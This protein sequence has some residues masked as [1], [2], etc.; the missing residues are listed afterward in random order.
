MIGLVSA[1]KYIPERYS[2]QSAFFKY[3]TDVNGDVVSM[4]NVCLVGRERDNDH[5]LNDLLGFIPTGN[6]VQDPNELSSNLLSRLIKLP[7]KQP[8][9]MYVKFWEF[10]LDRCSR[11]QL[12]TAVSAF[13]D[14][15]S[16]FFDLLV[17]NVHDTHNAYVDYNELAFLREAHRRN[18]VLVKCVANNKWHSDQAKGEAYRKLNEA[19]KANGLPNVDEERKTYVCVDRHGA[20]YDVHERLML[21]EALKHVVQNRYP[22]VYNRLEHGGALEIF[23]RFGRIQELIH[24]HS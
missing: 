9:T 4:V 10:N 18:I 13:F 16:A 11:E 22:A 12:P 17:L 23:T 19:F 24:M 20:T 5:R 14:R 7:N 21:A 15:Y 6:Q 1:L 3:E 2:N 8:T